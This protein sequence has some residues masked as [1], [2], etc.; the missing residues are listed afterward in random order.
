VDVDVVVRGDLEAVRLVSRLVRRLEDGRPA[1]VGLVD[2]ILFFQRE[3][4]EG[5]GTRWRRLAAG[6]LRWHRKRGRGAQPLILTG[7]LMRSLTDRGAPGQF[8]QIT[9]TTLSFGTRI[10]YARFHKRGLGV[11][12]RVPAG[13]TR[14]QRVDI[15]ER[16]RRL[17]T[18]DL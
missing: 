13:M 7:A 4:F 9:S 8:L 5:R 10:Y 16:F 15:V 11:P 18:A 12:K 17:L 14:G 6:T 2:R 3:R 1:L